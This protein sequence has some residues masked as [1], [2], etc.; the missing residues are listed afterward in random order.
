MSVI[1]KRT[2]IRYLWLWGM[3]VQPRYRG[4][5]ASG[6]L[7]ESVLQWG[8]RHYPGSTVRGSFHRNNRRAW[9]MVNRFG[10]VAV[11]DGQEFIRL[12]LAPEDHVVVECTTRSIFG[13]RK[14]A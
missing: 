4:T 14:S 3:Y 11:A 2:N 1:L 13:V 12:G 7:M 9:Q 6:L 10:F 8:E 5:P